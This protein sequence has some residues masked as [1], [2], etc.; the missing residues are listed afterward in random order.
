MNKPTIEP[1]EIRRMLSTYY[2]S[3]SGN[4][5]HSGTSQSSAWKTITKV[6]SVAFKPGDKILF[7]GGQTFTGSIKPLSGGSSTRPIVFGTFGSQRA[8]INSGKSDGAFVRNL[9]GVWFEFLQFRGTPNGNQHD[10][11]HVE[12]DGGGSR[13]NFGV[14]S[15]IIS[16]YGS[17]GV[18]FI[19]KRS[20]DLFA[21]VYITG[22]TIADCVDCG[23][24]MTAPLRNVHRNVHI[25]RNDIYAIWGDPSSRVTG[26]GIMVGGLNG[27]IIERNTVH[28]NGG[29]A[30]NGGAGIWAFASNNVTIQFNESYQNHAPRGDDGDGIDLDADTM[31]SVMQYNYVHDNDGAGLMFDQW[32]GNPYFT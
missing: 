8:I 28:Q 24:N 2:V 10:G 4:D 32:K 31:N 30:G 7:Q 29:R 12:L 14:D 9:T 25:A 6:N 23:V 27:A 15:C 17:A 5:Q 19:S 22:N 21:T 16:G 3:T 13:Q 20:N 11:V 26:S 1:L 18:H